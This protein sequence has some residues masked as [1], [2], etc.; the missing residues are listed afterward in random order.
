MAASMTYEH[1]RR[2]ARRPDVAM[3]AAEDLCCV[4]DH[5]RSRGAQGNSGAAQ[6]W[7]YSAVLR[8]RRDGFD[9]PITVL[10]VRPHP[11]P[12]RDEAA[13]EKLIATYDSSE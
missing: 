5:G 10:H 11:P 12:I 9:Q 4:D 6:M 8:A 3:R 7:P 2:R 13:A 1:E